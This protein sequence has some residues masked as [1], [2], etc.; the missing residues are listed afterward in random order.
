MFRKFIENWKTVEKPKEERIFKKPKL[1]WLGVVLLGGFALVYLMLHLLVLWE[2]VLPRNSGET[3]RYE[4][5]GWAASYF[6]YFFMMLIPLLTANLIYSRT[7]TPA[8]PFG[9]LIGG[10]VAGLLFMLKNPWF[11]G[12]TV[13]VLL[14]CI[15]VNAISQE[16]YEL[17]W[18]HQVY[19]LILGIIACYINAIIQMYFWDVWVFL[20]FIHLYLF[21]S[22]IAAV[23]IRQWGYMYMLGW[24]LCSIFFIF[25]QSL[26]ALIQVWISNWFNIF[27]IFPPFEQANIMVVA[28]YNLVVPPILVG[29]VLTYFFKIQRK[30]RSKTYNPDEQNVKIRMTKE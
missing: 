11:G 24:A 22:I 9:I 13:Y 26:L 21:I 20:Q 27:A 2:S 12:Y 18:W 5:P 14:L 16:K 7:K 17:K 4:M 30:V 1:E 19:Y 8:Y 15:L 6:I 29:S 28:I 3:V 23:K 25:R 10:T